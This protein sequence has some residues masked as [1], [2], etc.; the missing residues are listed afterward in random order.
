MGLPDRIRPLP[1]EKH[2]LHVGVPFTIGLGFKAAADVGYVAG[3]ELDRRIE[4]ERKR[5]DRNRDLFETLNAESTKRK[6][7][8]TA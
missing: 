7:E 8:E 5:N 2:G 1:Q 4:E 6:G 3:M